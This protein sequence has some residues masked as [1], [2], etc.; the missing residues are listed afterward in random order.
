M[1]ITQENKLYVNLNNQC[2]SVLSRYKSYWKVSDHNNYC[3]ITDFTTRISEVT[4]QRVI[5]EKRKTVHAFV[6]GT[7]SSEAIE[8]FEFIGS[9]SYNPYK[10]GYF[11][12]KLNGQDTVSNFQDWIDANGTD[13]YALIATYG[14]YPSI[15]LVKSLDV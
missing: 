4:R 13:G 11:T 10:A 1:K 5:A 12:L 2:F 14:E 7:V 8:N 3:T 6:L 15:K 9:V